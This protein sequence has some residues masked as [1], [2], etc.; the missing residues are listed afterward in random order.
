MKLRNVTIAAAA[1][2]VTLPAAASAQNISLK[3]LTAWDD[4]VAGTPLI[5]KHL[6]KMLEEESKGRITFKYSGPEVIKSRQQF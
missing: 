6:G 3:F 5:A 1:M 4:R 2:A